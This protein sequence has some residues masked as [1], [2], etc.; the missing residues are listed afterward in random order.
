MKN[1]IYDLIS[2]VAAFLLFVQCE[3]TIVSPPDRIFRELTPL[4]KRV[5]ESGDKFG[6]KL[7]REVIQAEKD[8]NVFISPL[9]VSMALGMTLNGANGGTFS[10]AKC[11]RLAAGTE[12]NQSYKSDGLLVQRSSKI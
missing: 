9:S 3:H 4:E 5:V 11:P 1:R 10:H 7:F 2:L 8:K 12:I 6:L